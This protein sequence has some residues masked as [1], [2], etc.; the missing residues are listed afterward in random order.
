[1]GYIAE[2]RKLV[3]SRPL[4]MAGAGVLVLDGAGRLLLQKRVDNG[5]WSFIGGSMEPGE[6]FEQTAR[7]E[8]WE[9]AGLEAGAL[10]LLE[11][12]SGPEFFYRYPN[13]DE[14]YNVGVLFLALE[15]RGS[16]RT[17]PSEGLELRYFG[18]DAL[19]DLSPFEKAALPRVRERLLQVRCPV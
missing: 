10:R 2:L 6:T 1:M 19:P 15:V 14:V 12:V 4:I 18:L 11:V 9:E 17:D 5:L 3:G 13:G 16:P 8:L 7:R